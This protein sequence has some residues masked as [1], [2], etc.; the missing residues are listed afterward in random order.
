MGAQI[1]IER[2]ALEEAGMEA[3]GGD[4][5]R[6]TDQAMGAPGVRHTRCEQ[7]SRAVAGSTT[8]GSQSSAIESR[9]TSKAQATRTPPGER[10]D[11]RAAQP[12]LPHAA[13]EA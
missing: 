7:Q 8:V 11:G 5:E 12:E 3:D 10:Y 4:V 2:E 9:R 1:A 6:A 13:G